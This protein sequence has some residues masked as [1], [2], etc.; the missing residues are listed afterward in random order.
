MFNFKREFTKSSLVLFLGIILVIGSFTQIKSTID[1]FSN[2]D[3]M[4]KI[5]SIY[6]QDDGGDGGDDGGDDDGSRK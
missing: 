4:I 6:A 1:F 3:Y 5:P 2:N